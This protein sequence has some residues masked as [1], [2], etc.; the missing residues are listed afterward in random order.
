[1]NRAECE[2]ALGTQLD[3][4]AAIR[5]ALQQLRGFG[6]PLVAVTFGARGMVAAW[7]DDVEAWQPPPIEVVNPIG[8]GDA[9]SAG[10]IDALSRQLEPAEA[11]R[12][13]MACAAANVRRWVACDF[14][15][16]EVTDLL[17]HVT[18]CPLDHLVA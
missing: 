16:S 14:Q 13:A 9:M 4:P 15:H 5:D 6:I 8:S 3:R 10:L 2:Q 7:D 17:P 18:V 11:C 12:W 1:M